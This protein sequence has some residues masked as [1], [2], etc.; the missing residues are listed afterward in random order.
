[1][2]QKSL[3]FGLAFAV[4]PAVSFGDAHLSCRSADCGDIT[5]HQRENHVFFNEGGTR[6]SEAERQRLGQLSAILESHAMHD[7]CL[8]LIGHADSV[9]EASANRRLAQRRAEVVAQELGAKIGNPARISSVISFGEDR[10]MPN[11]S[12]EHAWQRRVEIRA[13]KCALG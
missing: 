5:A 6:L 9:G 11:L 8:Q 10:P 3:I 1:M 2:R 7:A 12:K 13:R 4:F